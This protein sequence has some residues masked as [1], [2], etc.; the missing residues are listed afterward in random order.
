[1]RKNR[2]AQFSHSFCHTFLAKDVFPDGAQELDEKEDIEVLLRPLEDIPRLIREGEINHSLVLV[3]FYRFY[4]E[5]QQMGN[6]PAPL[7]PD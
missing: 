4:M 2:F 7:P 1:M 3:A 5:Y 6:S